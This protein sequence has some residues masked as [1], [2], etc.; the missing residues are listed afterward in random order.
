MDK[1]TE[2]YNQISSFERLKITEAQ[3]LYRKVIN[4]KNATLKKAYMDKLILGTLYVVYNYIKRNELELFI[5]SSYDIDDIIGAFNEIWVKKIYNGELLNVNKYSLLFTYQ[6]FN[7]VYNNLCGDEIIV[8][9][10]FDISTDCFVDLLALYISF[11]NKQSV[12]SFAQ[13]IKEQFYDTYKYYYHTYNIVNMIP[14]LEKIYNN[15]NFD[16]VDDLNLKQKKIKNYLKLIINIGLMESIANDLQ[17]END[18]EEEITKN[19]TMKQF[20]TDVDKALSDNRLIDVLHERFGLDGD[21]KSLEVVSI[22]HGIT[23]ERVRQI[24]SKALR[25]LRMKDR[26]RN[27]YS[28]I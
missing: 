16:K 12:K 17:D 11:K 9:E 28:D 25:K 10:L 19:I 6:Y 15:L 21:T 27:I 2:W 3:E 7:E 8:S 13:V 1:L 4:T 20:I 26:I 23:K 14:L 22:K 5:S 18:M 24:E